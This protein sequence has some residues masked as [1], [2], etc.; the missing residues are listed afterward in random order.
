MAANKA[1]IKTLKI[2]ELISKSDEGLTLSEI[3]READIPKATAYDILQ[4]LYSEDAVYYENEILK[5]YVVGSKLFTIGQSYIKNSNFISYASP[6]L[7]D[8]ATKYKVTTFACKRLG[9]KV[10]Y[11][12]KYESNKVR[13]LTSEIGTQLPLYQSVAGLAFLAFLPKDKSEELL[14]RILTKDFYGKETEEY[15]AIV[16]RVKE[17]R[18]QKYIY[19]NGSIDRYICELAVPVYNF[20][21]KV[22]G[23][24]SATRLIF[25]S[26]SET[27]DEK[28]Y[29]GEFLKIAETISHKQGYKK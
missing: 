11:V 5:T 18:T 10:T 16:A 20:E 21:N 1:V 24:I 9:T 19:D 27:E 3:Y 7:K 17:Y 6:L 14:E 8:F 22:T 25:E 26:E 2:L 28:E 29:V 4:A 23:V 15:Q 13:L 12:Y